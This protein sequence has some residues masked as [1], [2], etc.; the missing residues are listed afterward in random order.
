M[1]IVET[2][3]Q[4]Y[5]FEINSKSHYFALKY[6]QLTNYNNQSNRETLKNDINSTKAIIEAFPNSARKEIM[7]HH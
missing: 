5:F 3:G 6:P 1:Y 7:N 2:F 4:Y